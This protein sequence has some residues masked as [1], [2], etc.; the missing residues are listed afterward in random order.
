MEKRCLR[1]RWWNSEW[2][3]FLLLVSLLP[4]VDIS[5]CCKKHFSFILAGVSGVCRDDCSASFFFLQYFV[6]ETV[7]KG[8]VTRFWSGDAVT[9]CSGGRGVQCVGANGGTK[10]RRPVF[11]SQLF[12]LLFFLLFFW[13]KLVNLTCSCFSWPL[14]VTGSHT[15]DLYRVLRQVGAVPQGTIRGLFFKGTCFD[16]LLDD[17]TLV[18]FYCEMWCFFFFFRKLC[19]F[20]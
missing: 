7:C 17:M 6:Y 3:L 12:F 11:G 18:E 8:T 13:C 19:F 14:G 2:K 4:P 9:G 10:R 1:E 16:H 20:L 15:L 5:Y